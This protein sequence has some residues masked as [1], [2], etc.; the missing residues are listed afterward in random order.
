MR[1][2]KKKH[3]GSHHDQGDMKCAQKKFKRQ[4]NII[5]NFPI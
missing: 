1:K 4:K 2:N 5:D 3:L